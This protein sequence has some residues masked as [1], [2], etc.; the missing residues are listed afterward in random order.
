M[1]AYKN[2]HVERMTR[3][4]HH[5]DEFESKRI[6]FFKKIFLDCH[7][8]LQ[9][10]NDERFAE[11]FDTCLHRVNQANCKWD[12]DWFSSHYGINT[13]LKCPEFEEYT[14]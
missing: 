5:T 10:H 2:D 9:T 1:N 4:Y 6:F 13:Q 14:A 3:V 11:I 7:G 8:L 12:L